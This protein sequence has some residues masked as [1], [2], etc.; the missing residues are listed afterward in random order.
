MNGGARA[1]AGRAAGVEVL[2]LAYMAFALVWQLVVPPIVGLADNGDFGRILGPLGLRFTVEN[3]EEIFWNHVHRTY[4]LTEPYWHPGYYST[5]TAFA[6]VA[7]AVSKWTSRAGTFDIRLLGSLHAGI[8]LVAIRLA[9]RPGRCLPPILRVLTSALVALVFTDVAYV[10]SFNSF[11]SQT[12]ALLAFLVVI[13]SFLRLAMDPCSARAEAIYWLAAT[14]FVLAKPQESVQA[15]ILA[16]LGVVMSFRPGTKRPQRIR[17]L[18]CAVLLCVLAAVYF[19]AAPRLWTGIA[20]YFAVFNELLLQSPDAAADARELGIP[21]DWLA[22]AGTNPWG[23]TSVYQSAEFQEDFRAR[24]SHFEVVGFYARHPGRFWALIE[25]SSARA[26]DMRESYLGNFEPH[27]GPRRLATAFAAWSTAKASVGKER[28]WLLLVLLLFNT[29]LAAFLVARPGYPVARS[30]GFGL[31]ALLAMGGIE[32]LV[33]IL[34]ESGPHLVR[35]WFCFH[36]MVDVAV[37]AD[38][39]VV[40]ALCAAAYRRLRAR[41]PRNDR[42]IGDA[43]AA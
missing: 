4:R 14:A 30:L 39:V 32:L 41:Q 21:E 17:A 16:A 10:A 3:R 12:A 1:N 29:A 37:I 18:A 24:V 15:P 40:A 36:A 8:L 38:A 2:L 28:E 42:G 6:W 7:L 34:A 31:V 26:F 23:R 25:R 33:P 27:L 43:A 13:A 9:Q 35:H 5:E 19:R 11:Y 22:Y 20:L